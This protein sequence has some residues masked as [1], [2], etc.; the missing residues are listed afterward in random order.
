MASNPAVELASAIQSASINRAPSPHHDVNPSTAASIKV[1][2]EVHSPPES[3]EISL[4]SD[5]VDPS[6]VIKPR[7]RSGRPT[8]PPLPDFRFEQSYLASIKDADTNWKVAY[9]T[10]RDQVL[11]PLVQGTIWTLLLNGWRYYNRGVNLQGRTIGSRI[12]RWW[13]EVNNWE[14]P[15]EQSI[16]RQGP[17]RDVKEV[18][19]LDWLMG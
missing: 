13:W 15:R 4:S 16:Q 10:I 6:N 3:D 11:L 7:P 12:R 9:I 5:V 8:F 14:V 17:A 18:G 19:E 2:A 1:P